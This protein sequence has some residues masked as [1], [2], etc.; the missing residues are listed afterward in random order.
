M[1]D[2]DVKS[3]SE[4]TL[5]PQDEEGANPINPRDDILLSA[6]K[7]FKTN[8]PT[9]W[10]WAFGANSG[11][12][13]TAGVLGSL[14]TNDLLKKM[15]LTGGEKV[16]S[17][18]GMFYFQHDLTSFMQEFDTHNGQDFANMFSYCYNLKSV[19]IDI[20]NAT[21]IGYMFAYCYNL[22]NIEFIGGDK[23]TLFGSIFNACQKL[24]KAPLFNTANVFTNSGNN[25]FSACLALE[26]VPAYDFSKLTSATNMFS[27]CSKLKK[28]HFTGMTVAFDISAST[29][30]EREDLVEVLTNL[31]EAKNGSQTLTMGETNLAKLTADDIAI[32]TAKGW[33]LA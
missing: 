28:I 2:Y 22:E 24:K 4:I 11:S 3:N 16:T 9:Y 23:I 27:A 25:M 12:I 33:T 13:F 31:G 6:W 8:N 30:F 19:K 32:A 14:I 18:R 5:L 26:E 15:D 17:F 10:Y 29:L 20:T 21:D 1:S 7:Q